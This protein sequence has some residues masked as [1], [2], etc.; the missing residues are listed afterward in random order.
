MDRA[1]RDYPLGDLRVSD[2]DRD[3]AL[4]ELSE[5]FQAGRITPDELE[6][7]SGQVLAART[8]TELTAPLADLP[9]SR[10]PVARTTALERDHRVLAAGISVAAAVAA[11]GFAAVA[12]GNAVLIHG[13]TLHQRELL[14]E[15]A[16]RQGLP[17]PPAFPPNPGF[18]WAGTITPAAIAVLLVML[19]IFLRVNVRALSGG[20]GGV[21]SGYPVARNSARSGDTGRTRRFGR[22]PHRASRSRARP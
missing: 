22:V 20:R 7:R 5:A 21:R 11:I 17:V 19:I 10:V 3:R 12:A 15:F 1:A 13:P 6:Q 4:G 8:G 2:A 9:V 14:R 18:D 16:V